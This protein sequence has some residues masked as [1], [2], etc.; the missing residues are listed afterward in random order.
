MPDSSQH[1]GSAEI[2]RRWYELGRKFLA[3]YPEGRTPH[4][5][6]PA[7]AAE[8]GVSLDEVQKAKRFRQLFT[9]RDFRMITTPKRGTPLGWG[10]VRKLLSVGDRSER[11]KIAKAAIADGMTV[12]AVSEHIGGK[13]QRTNPRG[14]GRK[15]KRASSDSE[16]WVRVDRK[17]TAWLQTVD[18]RINDVAD[19]ASPALGGAIE[20]SLSRMSVMML[21]LQKALSRNA[22]PSV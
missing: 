18:D 14:A 3:A 7:F 9:E 11:M 12:S 6:I 8:N 1:D 5:A 10:I 19:P 22:S 20:E 16:W 21:R 2:L 15:A 17:S 4:G 13:Y